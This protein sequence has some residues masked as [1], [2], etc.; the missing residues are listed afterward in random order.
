MLD[1]KDSLLVTIILL[2]SSSD[3]F[4]QNAAR[5]NHM[6]HPA[7]FVEINSDKAKVVAMSSNFHQDAVPP[8]LIG[9]VTKY[10]PESPEFE[11][12]FLTRERI[13]YSILCSSWSSENA[14]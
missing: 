11:Q 3:D 13:A 8:H 14:R 7:V 9:Q 2:A 6:T 1:Q 10:F 5:Q 12:D 4:L